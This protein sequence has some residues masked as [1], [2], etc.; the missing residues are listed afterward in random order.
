MKLLTLM[1]H[2][3]SSWDEAGLPDHLR[4]LNKR[5][6]RDAPTMAARLSSYG[7]RPDLLLSSDAVRCQMTLESLL[8]HL[9]W[10]GIA[11][12]QEH[13]LYE[14]SGEDIL[15]VL[16]EQSDEAKHIFV[17]GH[18]P[19]LQQAFEQLSEHRAEKFPTSAVISL[20]LYIEQWHKIRTGC[21]EV[22]LYD[23]PK[24]ALPTIIQ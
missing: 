3:K 5:G 9:P 6:R 10:A 16:S 15:D 12:T 11:L 7:I 21:G 23:A 2:A 24:L 22:T 17:L 20:T 1:R 8:D 13:R 4:P 18:N 19:G 14:C